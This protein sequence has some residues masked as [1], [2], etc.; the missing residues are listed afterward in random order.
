MWAHLGDYLG[1]LMWLDS[2]LKDWDIADSV[3]QSLSTLIL[4]KSLICWTYHWKGDCSHGDPPSMSR[5]D[6]VLISGDWEEQFPDV[7]QRLLP[8]LLSYHSLILIEAG[9]MAHGKSPL[10]FEIMWLKIEG[11]VEKVQTCWSMYSFRGTLS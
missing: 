9:G 6:R 11:F 2:R 4:L 1:I 10:R 5:I 8:H 3:L 7:T